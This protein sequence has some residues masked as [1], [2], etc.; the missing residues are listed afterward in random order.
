MKKNV[1]RLTESELKQ[2]ISK[3]I[4]E[5][6]AA[7]TAEKESVEKT[8]S[9]MK[10]V[11]GKNVQLY[12]DSAKTK[13]SHLVNITQVG[14]SKTNPGLYWLYTKDLSY[15]TSTG[16]QATPTDLSPVA[17]IK[18]LRFDCTEPGQFGIMGDGGKNLGVAFCPPL[19]ELV[20]QTVG[21]QTVNLKADFAAAKPAVAAPVAAKPDFA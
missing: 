17:P 9:L 3:V 19:S 7:P 4:A 14:F 21:C 15:V 11:G 13:K 1:I 8:N 20:K 6:S 16:A 2:Y 12:L 5:Q 18:Y 10:A